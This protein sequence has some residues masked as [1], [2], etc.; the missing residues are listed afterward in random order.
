ML[1]RANDVLPRRVLV[2]DGSLLHPDTA[3]GRAINGLVE[4]FARRGVAVITSVSFEDGE[5][6][7][8]SDAGLGAVI[9]DWD[10]D[11][12]KSASHQAAAQMLRTIRDR[13]AGL[14]IFLLAKRSAEQ[15]IT[16]DAMGQADELV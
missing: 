10:L 14:P 5:A 4:E 3:H 2:V 1:N 8:T 9:V 7:V 13:N 15:S 16:I 6:V 12:D 11:A